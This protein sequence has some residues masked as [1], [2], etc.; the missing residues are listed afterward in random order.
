VV[1]TTRRA[2]LP[3]SVT[4]PR[5]PRLRSVQYGLS[6][7]LLTSVLTTFWSESPRSTMGEHVTVS[8]CSLYSKSS[9]LY[10]KSSSLYSK[11]SSLYSKSSAL[12]SKSSSLYSKSSSLYSK[13][14]SLYS[15]SSSLYSKSSSLYSKSSS[16][17]SKPIL[18]LQYLRRSKMCIPVGCDSLVL[19][20]FDQ[21]YPRPVSVIVSQVS[22]E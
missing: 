5:P 7:Q 12:Y 18:T 14:S 19:P 15:M 11:S 17:Y 3:V 20:L 22:T 13:S 10:S 16:L 21:S 9:S 4:A 1:I 6:K 8:P 2:R